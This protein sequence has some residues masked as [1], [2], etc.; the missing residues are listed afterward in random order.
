MSKAWTEGYFTDSGYTYGYYREINPVF[1]RFCLLAHGLAP[2]VQAS[3]QDGHCELGY[4][5]GVSANIHAAAQP[6]QWVGTD[7]NPSHALHARGLGA[8]A[9]HGARWLD[10]SFEQM[11]QRTD[12]PPFQSISLHGIWTWVSRDNQRLIV[13]F[14]RRHLQPGGVLYVSYNCFP[15][16]APA[17]PLR[18]VLALHDRFASG[19]HDV[20]DRVDAALRFAEDLLKAG[21]L[22]QGAVPG[23]GD[24]LAQM[25][26]QNRHYL[27]HEYF[28]REWNCMYFTDVVDALAQAKL[29]YAGSAAPLDMVDAIHLAPQGQ[30]F[31]Q[32]IG[33]PILREQ[34]RDYFV[35]RQ[36]R[37]DLFVRG[38]RRLPQA[39][40]RQLLLDTRI[41]LVQRADLVSN[42]VAGAAGEASLQEEI[43]QPLLA[44]MAAQDYA[45]KSLRVLQ[46]NVPQLSS[47]H[48]L[49][50]II[51]LIGMGAAAPCQPEDIA[52]QV[53]P[54][55]DALNRHFCEKAQ[56]S[57]DVG[58]LASPVTGGGVSVGR[59]AMLF[60]LARA[61]GFER[62][63]QWA[64]WAWQSLK[65]QG[66]HLLKDG[67]VLAGDQ[68]NLLELTRQAADF[69]ESGLAP[70][71]ALQV[72]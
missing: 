56:F 50:A 61:Q 13:E 5:Q 35:N 40:Q 58:V 48:L 57:A 70:L 19:Q 7:F 71:R 28:N 25:G 10:D 24:R 32:T 53:R 47:A 63:D 51:V 6:G 27:A 34:M 9:G 43:Y 2:T 45:P 69:S 4:G 55:C 37:K 15:G 1:Q 31:L 29:E 44:A 23:L 38:V 21:P 16:W 14:A 11:L 36:F 49:Q 20:K 12:L 65:A 64:S 41:V 30:A 42:K 52:R 3:G 59:F 46:A 54:R 39:E 68:E 67:S 72:I 66:E 17:Y 8:A 60:L 26:R 33:A 18:Q 62:P 22:Y